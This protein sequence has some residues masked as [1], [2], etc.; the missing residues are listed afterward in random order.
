[1]GVSGELLVD[2]DVLR[3]HAGRVSGV[4]SELAT[5][6]AAAATTD[7]HGGAFGVL[8]SFLPPIV[9]GVDGAAR[10]ALHAVRGAAAEVVADLGD[11]AKAFD[12]V[13]Q[14]VEAAFKKILGALR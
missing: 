5:A 2:S 14:A 11:M 13:D 7:L 3:Q 10:D 12:H 6:T 8:C 1:V 9:S 4:D